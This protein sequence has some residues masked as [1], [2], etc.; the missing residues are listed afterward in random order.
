MPTTDDDD[1][2]PPPTVAAPLFGSIEYPKLG[3]GS[4]CVDG[5]PNVVVRPKPTFDDDCWFCC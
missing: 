3:A 4:N 5:R 1:A 2:A